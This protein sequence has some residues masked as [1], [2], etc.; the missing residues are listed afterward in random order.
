MKILITNIASVTAISIVKILKRGKITDLHIWG[1]E[2]QK[3]GYNS[4]SMIVEHYIQVP[5]V[6][7]DSY[8]QNIIEIC[9]KYNINVLIPILDEELYLFSKFRL[10]NYVKILLPDVKIIEL[11]RNKFLASTELNNIHPGISPQIYYDMSSVDCEKVIIRKKQ[12]IGS[13]GIIVKD[14]KQLS[15][16]DFNN[17]EYFVQRYVEG[18]EYTV[19]IL[20]DSYGNIKLIIPRKRLQIK[21]GVS[22]KVEITNDREIIDLCRLIYDKYCIPGLSNMQ[23]IKKDSRIYFIEMNM[24]FAGMG[25]AGILASYDYIS[26]YILYLICNRDLG[27]F[28]NNM[29][30]IKWGAVICRYYEETVLMQ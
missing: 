12:S 6:S 3:Y 20:A 18:T 11:F 13:Q 16:S 8:V 23:F 19:D 14:K 27:D 1:T 15:F 21:N 25:I 28:A 2:T 7:S 30:K 29:K 9:Q 4:G 26:D 17:P 24:R 10:Q 5:E 22:T